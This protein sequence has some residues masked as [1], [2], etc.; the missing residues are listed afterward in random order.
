MRDVGRRGDVE[1][2]PAA[3]DAGRHGPG[4]HLRDQRGIAA[5]GVPAAPGDVDGQGDPDHVHQAVEVH[6]QRPDVEA[7]DRGAGQE[8]QRCGRHHAQKGMPRG[9]ARRLSR[10][11]RAGGRRCGSLRGL[12]ALSRARARSQAAMTSSGLGAGRAGQRVPVRAGDQAAA[13]PA[14]PPLGADPAGCRDE[15]PVGERRGLDVS[16]DVG[17]LPRR[18]R[19][20]GPV[21]GH[22]Q[23]VSAGQGG[24]PYPLRELDV[25]ADH[26]RD[27]AELGGHDRRR[28][29]A[30]GEEVALGVP[31]VRLAV[32]RAEPAGVGQHRAVVEL[33]VVAELGEA[34]D[35]DHA[36]AAASSAHSGHRRA[37]GGSAAARASA[38]LSNT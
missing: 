18:H 5:G 20:G 15:H 35:D 27:P 11:A 22:G 14:H 34:A 24:Q 37:A 28:G 30:G 16:H 23:Q 26:H 12:V 1:V 31:Q 9:R 38:G 21:G 32:H 29:A 17:P 19:L 6:E 13:D 7:V 8:A 3:D 25:V 4:G 36:E 33:A 2:D 10:R